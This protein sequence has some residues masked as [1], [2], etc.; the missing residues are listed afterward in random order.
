MSHLLSN[1]KT[2]NKAKENVSLCSIEFLRKK[3][4]EEA[5]SFIMHVKNGA[6]HLLAM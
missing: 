3:C 4:R 5:G 6:S 2:E 1:I